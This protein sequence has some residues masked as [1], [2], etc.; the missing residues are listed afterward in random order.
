MY[1]NEH[2]LSENIIANIFL[3]KANPLLKL[4][5]VSV[6]PYAILYTFAI[7]FLV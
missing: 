4:A 2:P 7:V 5:P 6:V 1:I 3:T